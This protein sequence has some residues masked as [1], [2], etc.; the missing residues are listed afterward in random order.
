MY[1]NAAHRSVVPQRRQPK[2]PATQ[3]RVTKSKVALSSN[4]TSMP[5]R[6][7]PQKVEKIEVSQRPKPI[8]LS[9]LLF[10]Q[11]SSDLITFVLVA[12]TLSLYSLTVYTQQQ[13]S[14]SFR[15]LEKMQ[16]EE[17]QLTAAN[18]DM[19]NHLAQ[20]AER[21]GTGLVPPTQASKIVLQPAP[22]RPA[23]QPPVVSAQPETVA[24]TPLGY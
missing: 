23:Q 14:Q 8:W 4:V 1:M 21:P 22:Q 5:S 20:Q 15:D 6:T 19:K 13:W 12:A 24:K 7:A 3:S 18:E 9:S 2:R 11:R 10:L 16:R 17:R